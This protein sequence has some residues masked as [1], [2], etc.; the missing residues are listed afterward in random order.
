MAESDTKAKITR[1]QFRDPGEVYEQTALDEAF[2]GMRAEMKGVP[3][4]AQWRTVAERMSTHIPKLA[5]LRYRQPTLFFPDSADGGAGLYY[6]GNVAE[7]PAA[8]VLLRP[9]SIAGKDAARNLVQ[10]IMSPDDVSALVHAGFAAVF[11]TEALSEVAE[12]LEARAK[13][14]TPDQVSELW[15]ENFPVVFVPGPDGED[16]QITPITPPTAYDTLHALRFKHLTREPDVNGRQPFRGHWRRAKISDKFGNIC[17]Q[18]GMHMTLLGARFPEPPVAREADLYA[19]AH[20]GR[21]PRLRDENV[22]QSLA[23]FLD[24]FQQ[25]VQP[26]AGS[27]YLNPAIEQ[28]LID[29]AR[30]LVREAEAL[31]EATH[32]RLEDFAGR[33]AA[34]QKPAVSPLEVLQRVLPHGD[35]QTGLLRDALASWV[36]ERALSQEGIER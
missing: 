26:E 10:H 2:A 35:R 32:E 1:L 4:P 36:F 5:G 23:R 17:V 30:L 34:D 14:T 11:G 25:H 7:A 18:I 6:S 20:G 19:Y 27:G 22:R 28:G 3:T 21:H 33:E 31:I 29:H 12:V 16:R 13:Q 9:I 24:R 8:K 15:P